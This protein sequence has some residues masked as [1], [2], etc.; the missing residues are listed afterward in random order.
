MNAGRRQ[1]AY[2]KVNGEGLCS[3][4]AVLPHDYPY[5]LLLIQAQEQ[6]TQDVHY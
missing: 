3:A 1:P 2:L 4:M 5:Q 6:L